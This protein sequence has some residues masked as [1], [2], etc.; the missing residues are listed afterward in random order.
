MEIQN[1]DPALPSKELQ[2]LTSKPEREPVFVKGHRRALNAD[3][4]LTQGKHIKKESVCLADGAYEKCNVTLKPFS[5]RGFFPACTQTR[6]DLLTT[7]WISCV[8][9]RLSCPVKVMCLPFCSYWHALLWVALLV[10]GLAFQICWGFLWLCCLQ[11]TD[12]FHCGAAHCTCAIRWNAT[13]LQRHLATTL[14]IKHTHTSGLPVCFDLC[15]W[16]AVGCFFVLTRTFQI[17]AI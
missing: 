6:C 4:I 7:A 2:Y 8:S 17:N 1:T 12:C 14:T 15:V 11:V 16:V 5:C 10:V 3:S 13:T 9:V